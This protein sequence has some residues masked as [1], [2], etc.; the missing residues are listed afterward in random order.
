MA[1]PKK[2]SITVEEVGGSEA[3][4]ETYGDPLP[5]RVDLLQE[6]VCAL[7][8]RIRRRDEKDAR[9]VAVFLRVLAARA[10]YWNASRP[11]PQ[12]GE[13]VNKEWGEYRDL[14]CEIA[15]GRTT[16]AEHCR[17]SILDQSRLL[18]KYLN[19]H[20]DFSKCRNLTTRLGWIVR[21]QEAMLSLLTVIPC[22][23]IYK[24]A[25]T[26]KPSHRKAMETMLTPATFRNIILGILH[27]TVPGQIEKIRKGH[28][29][30]TTDELLFRPLDAVIGFPSFDDDPPNISFP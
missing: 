3:F 7:L 26:P 28:G 19:D 29:S 21:H 8:N 17:E 20:E 12:D 25:L 23:C 13:A 6:T 11:T 16:K 14:L 24:G 22:F 5:A 4:K 10:A 18:D 30:F 9:Q 1:R 27:I 2:T 15:L